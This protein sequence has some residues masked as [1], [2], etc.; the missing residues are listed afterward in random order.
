MNEISIKTKDQ[1]EKMRAGGSIAARVLKMLSENI[2]PGISIIE[3]DKMAEDAI[4]S[5]GA[6]PSFKGYGG[7]PAATCISL[8]EEIVHGIP[9]KRKIKDGDVVGIDIGVYYQGFHT[10]TAITVGVGKISSEAKKLID[11]TKLSLDKAIEMIK[12]LINIGDVQEVI[13]NTIENAGFGVIR[14]LSGH[15]VGKQLQEKPSIPNFGKRG[16]G[17]ILKEGM[18]LAFEP[19]VSAGGYKV[20]V[21]KKNGWTVKIADGSLGAHFEHTIVVTKDGCEVLTRE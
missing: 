1:I 16:T 13:Q 12:P 11:I 20:K 8:N 17:I 4:N 21:D 9:S 15:G 3:L 14:D 5:S 2:K 19:M 6:T 10:D 18:T 7:Y